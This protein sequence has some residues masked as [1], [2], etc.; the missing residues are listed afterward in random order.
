MARITESEKERF[1]RYIRLSLDKL[2]SPKNRKKSHWLDCKLAYLEDR[3]T[4]EKA[5]Y[6][7]ARTSNGE[8]SISVEEYL[9]LTDELKDII[10]LSLMIWDKLENVCENA[11]P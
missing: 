9:A 10:N 5:E 11:N 1:L 3:L 7:E 2:E 6:D 8:D 4:E